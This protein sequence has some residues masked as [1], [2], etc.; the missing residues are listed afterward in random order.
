MTT[1]NRPF[2]RGINYPSLMSP[3]FTYEVY[4]NGGGN[5][6]IT[7]MGSGWTDT[8]FKHARFVP[9]FSR[10]AFS[11]YAVPDGC[12]IRVTGVEGG[13]ALRIDLL[14]A[15]DIMGEP[16]ATTMTDRIAIVYHQSLGARFDD[17]KNYYEVNDGGGVFA[18]S[19]LL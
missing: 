9:S 19:G 14:D 2:D 3:A 11:Y 18:P 8:E 15:M 1:T 10:A 16:I 17:L 4:N 13:D 6:G 7:D 12:R 5:L